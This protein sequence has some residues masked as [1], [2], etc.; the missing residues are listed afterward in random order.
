MWSYSEIEL[1]MPQEVI[2]PKAN[3][4]WFAFCRWLTKVIIFNCYGRFTSIGDE[5]VPRTGAAIIA[6]VHVS[7]LDPPAVACGSARQ[8]RY[9]AKEEL[10]RKKW[11]RILI[12]SLG[13]FP[14]KRGEGD[15][16]SIRIS[17]EMLKQGE[18]LVL[19]PEGTRGDGKTLLPISRGVAMLAK[20]TKVPII[21]VGII[22]THTRMPV[23]TLKIKRGDVTVVYGTPFT[24][25][26][27]ATSEN[28][29]ENRE[30][31]SDFLAS[32]I[33]ELCNQHGFD[34]KIS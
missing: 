19:F 22:G 11:A 10:F 8:M 2:T 4:L 16:E 33:V 14:V 20:K 13:A 24:Y 34:I 7:H 30:I 28:E 5:N 32:R 18:A 1:K 12:S 21:P 6:P 27:V 23:G 29:R 17:L 31:F 26:E 15:T 9:M 3:P 25:D